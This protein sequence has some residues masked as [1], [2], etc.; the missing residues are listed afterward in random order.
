MDHPALQ[1]YLDELRANP[2]PHPSTIEIGRRRDAYRAAATALWPSPQPI[3][4]VRDDV[5]DLV[6]RTVGTRLYVP[7]GDEMKGLVVYFHGGSFIVGDLDTHDGVCRRIAQDTSMRVLAID[8]RL[9]PEH[10]FPAG[11]DDAVDVLRYV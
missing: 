1:A 5:I 8:Y 4:A 2:A 6:G 7:S 11:L 3:G 9:A 10:P